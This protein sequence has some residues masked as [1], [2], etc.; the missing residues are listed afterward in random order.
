MRYVDIVS[1][2]DLGLTLEELAFLLPE[3]ENSFEAWSQKTE[4]DRSNKYNRRNPFSTHL[5]GLRAPSFT[6]MDAIEGS[7][8]HDLLNYDPAQIQNGLMIVETSLDADGLGLE[9][10]SYG[11]VSVTNPSG[12]NNFLVGANTISQYSKSIVFNLARVDVDRGHEDRPALHSGVGRKLELNL[13]A[14]QFIL[15]VRGDAGFYTPCGVQINTGH[16]NDTPPAMTF[17]RHGAVDFKAVLEDLL[18]GVEAELSILRAMVAN[19]ASKKGDYAAFVE[20]SRRISEA[21]AKV[22]DEVLAL[23]NAKGAAE[24]QR[25]HQQFI[26]EMNERLAQLN[27]GQTVEELLGLTQ[28]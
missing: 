10:S 24:G 25:A 19:G 6:A 22:V 11:A 12:A 2:R 26:T 5:E 18:Q 28:G 1:A 23:G 17:D 14:E 3:A 20:Q 4:Y 13:S 7:T 9:H 21:Y 27:I 8:L 16:W 15:M